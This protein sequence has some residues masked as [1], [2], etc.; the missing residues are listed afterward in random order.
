MLFPAFTERILFFSIDVSPLY[1]YIYN[2]ADRSRRFVFS[3][4]EI[5]KAAS[6]SSETMRSGMD[7]YP[8][9]KKRAQFG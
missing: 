3:P 8:V 2:T 9:K 6:S 7:H 1:F 4:Q 5:V